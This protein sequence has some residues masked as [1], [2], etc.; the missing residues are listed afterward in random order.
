MTDPDLAVRFVDETN[1][2]LLAVTIGNVHGRYLSPPK[3]DLER[4]SFIRRSVSSRIPLV[5]HGASGLDT[6]WI[7][8]CIL[9]GISKFNV[10]TEMREAAVLS[11]DKHVSLYFK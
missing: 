5:L 1:I 8:E 3:L 4:L 6:K 2:D 11:Y 10:N 7:G 9:R